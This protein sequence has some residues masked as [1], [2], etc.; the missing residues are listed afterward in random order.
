MH[1]AFAHRYGPPEQIEIGE[2]PMP[3]LQSGRVLVRVHASSLNPLDYHEVTGTPWVARLSTGVLRRSTP[4][5]GSDVAGVIE[6][7]GPDV[8]E[9]TVGDRVFGTAPGAWATFAAP[10]ATSLVRLPEHVSFEQA[11]AIP[12]AGVTALQAL[13]D[14]AKVAAGQRVLV[15]GAAG[16]VGTFAVQIAAYLGAHVTAVCSARNVELAHGLGAHRVVDYGSED[17]VEVA[18]AEGAFDVILDNVG[19]RTLGECRR[20]MTRRGVYVIVGGPKRNRVVGPLGRMLRAMARFAVVR[21]SAAPILARINASDL[22]ELGTMVDA[23]VVRSVVDRSI[24][25][26]EVPRALTELAG[27]HV[28]GKIAVSMTRADRPPARP[29][30]HVAQSVSPAVR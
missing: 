10:K 24:G 20:M 21:Q 2:W 27:G 1:A 13:R 26:D 4:V 5:C 12:V 29:A 16:G 11:A 9:W 6:A 23:G 18:R 17:V 25:L 7:V 3:E 30:E 8:S 14:K 19:N 15:N 28:R 22:G